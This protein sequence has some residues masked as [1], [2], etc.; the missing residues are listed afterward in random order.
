VV[1]PYR[2]VSGAALGVVKGGREIKRRTM[3]MAG[4]VNERNPHVDGYWKRSRNP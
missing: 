4:E 1:H 2:R 3:G